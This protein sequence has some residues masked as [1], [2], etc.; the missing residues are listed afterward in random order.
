MSS[1][2]YGKNI[3]SAVENTFLSLYVGVE[4]I[5][6]T[7]VC[8]N[9]GKKFEVFGRFTSNHFHVIVRFNQE[10][11]EEIASPFIPICKN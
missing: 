10:K 6:I 9:S 4:P 2:K 11:A 8:E 5:P 3:S 1:C 7:G